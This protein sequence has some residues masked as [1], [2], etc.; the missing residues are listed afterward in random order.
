MP[1][2]IF[3][4]VWTS[5][6]RLWQTEEEGGLHWPVPKIPHVPGI[7]LWCC[8]ILM[9][10][11]RNFSGQPWRAGRQQGGGAAA[12]GGVRGCQESRLP[13]LGHEPVKR[14][15]KF[16]PKLHGYEPTNEMCELVSKDRVQHPCMHENLCQHGW[17]GNVQRKLKGEIFAIHFR[18][19]LSVPSWMVKYNWDVSK[20]TLWRWKHSIIYII[21]KTLPIHNFMDTEYTPHWC[22]TR[23]WTGLDLNRVLSKGPEFGTWSQR[24][25]RKVPNLQEKVKK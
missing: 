11:H 2:H 23:W 17:E 15:R 21:P 10:L 8:L 16:G 3:Q 9:L 4:P 19:T 1:S 18:S 7:C 13:F 22:F 6:Q 12:G 14:L 5:P 20:P 25:P 24:G